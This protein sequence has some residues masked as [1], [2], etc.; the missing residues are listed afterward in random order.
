M[1]RTVNYFCIL[2][3]Y[4]IL[5]KFSFLTEQTTAVLLGSLLRHFFF[6]AKAL[7]SGEGRAFWGTVLCNFDVQKVLTLS[8]V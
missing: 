5:Y 8:L 7:G 4:F 1:L 6:P 3:L 2:V